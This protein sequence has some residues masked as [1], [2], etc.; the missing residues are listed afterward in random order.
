MQTA[1]NGYHRTFFIFLCSITTD[2]LG[3]SG[4]GPGL[5]ALVRLA[6]VILYFF[7]VKDAIGVGGSWSENNE[8][9]ETKTVK[10]MQWTLDH[11]DLLLFSSIQL[12][13]S[14][15]YLNYPHHLQRQP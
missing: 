10:L 11:F 4:T 6:A 3:E 15:L 1:N 5:A 8:Q 2:Q 9:V 7:R 14:F 13:F 12:F